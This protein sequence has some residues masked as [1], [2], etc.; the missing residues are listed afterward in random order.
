MRRRY[1]TCRVPAY[2]SVSAESLRCLASTALMSRCGSDAAFSL[3]AKYEPRARPTDI[4]DL[5]SDSQGKLAC[6][7]GM[8]SSR[9]SKM[10][11]MLRRGRS[12]P[13]LMLHASGTIPSRRMEMVHARICVWIRVLILNARVRAP[14]TEVVCE[15]V[16]E[17]EGLNSSS[18]LPSNSA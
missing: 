8:I 12:S 11:I 7:A 15:R 9:V 5:A 14:F 10:F 18:T 4:P 17:R 1:R 13:K 3:K 16:C 2:V 6:R